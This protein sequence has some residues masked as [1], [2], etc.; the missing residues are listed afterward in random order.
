M[1]NIAAPIEGFY[2]DGIFEVICGSPARGD[3][4]RWILNQVQNDR[5]GG[6]WNDKP[7]R[8]LCRVLGLCNTLI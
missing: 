3:K 1:A 5:K 7:D 2:R 8:M 4:R 6:G